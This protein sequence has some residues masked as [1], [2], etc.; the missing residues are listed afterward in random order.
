MTDCAQAESSRV[1]WVQS[2]LGLARTVQS[3][4]AALL[5]LDRFSLSL[6][7]FLIIGDLILMK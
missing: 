2:I 5:V 4:T 3:T 1:D 7:L 6:A